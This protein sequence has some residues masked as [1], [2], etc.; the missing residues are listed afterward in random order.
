MCSRSIVG[1]KDNSARSDLASIRR[2]ADEW[3]V[4]MNP[5]HGL[6]EIEAQGIR[7]QSR[8][9]NFA[10]IQ[11]LYHNVELYDPTLLT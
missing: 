1:V 5:L 2:R 3:L 11:W 4:R 9:G 10:R 6:N 8:D 7:D